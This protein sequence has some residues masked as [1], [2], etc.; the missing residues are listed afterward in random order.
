MKVIERN[1][2][3]EISGKNSLFFK[4][5]NGQVWVETVIYTLIGLSIIGMVL[6]FATPK[7]N[8]YKTEMLVEKSIESMTNIDLKIAEVLSA[9][10]NQRIVDLKIGKGT[11]F[12]DLDG[13]KIYWIVDSS[14][15][16]SEEDTPI[17]V[18][19]FTVTTKRDNEWSV[20]IEKNYNFVFKF[21]DKNEG[22]KELTAA[23]TPYKLVI[24]NAGLNE[25]GETIIVFRA[26]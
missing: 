13:S 11:L 7:I 6:A 15:E 12:F 3:R 1:N 26:S 9:Q 8:N 16:Y 4:N 18:G 5:K 2:S 19:T 21:D 23:S 24:E 10:G 17:Q 25:Y 20:T 22:I 14:F